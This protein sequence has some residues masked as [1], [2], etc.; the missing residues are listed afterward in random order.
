MKIKIQPLLIISFFIMFT[1]NTFSQEDNSSDKQLNNNAIYGNAGIGGLW[2]TA[3]G[4][5][6]RMLKQSM[7]GKRISSF[8]RAGYGGLAAW[9]VETGYFL[10]QV[11]ILT[12]L[13]THHFELSMGPIYYTNW[14]GVSGFSVSGNIGWRIQKPE[15]PFLF[16]MGLGFPEALFIGFGFSF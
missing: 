2:F 11:G 1:S 4:Y 16:R 10:A 13:K 14:G 5:Y 9:E 7:S 3:T 15:S 12:G 6:E 8:A